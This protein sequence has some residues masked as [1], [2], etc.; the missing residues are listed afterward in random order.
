MYHAYS[1]RPLVQQR[2]SVRN[3]VRLV[4]WSGLLLCLRLHAA[5]LQLREL[6]LDLLE[7]RQHLLV[8]HLCLLMCLLV[9]LLK[10]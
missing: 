4:V 3:Q 7:L 8:Q 5:L 10:L 1:R 9:A 2:L 6:L